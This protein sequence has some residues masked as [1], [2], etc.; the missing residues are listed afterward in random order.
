MSTQKED[1]TLSFPRLQ[2]LSTWTDAHKKKKNL[3]IPRLWMVGFNAL[4]AF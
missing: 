2:I 1:P 3:I 4:T